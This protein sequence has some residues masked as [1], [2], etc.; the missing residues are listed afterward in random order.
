MDVFFAAIESTALSVWLRD[1]PSLLAFPFVLILH[2]VGLAFL[3]GVNVAVCARLLGL[4]AAV[5]LPSLTRYFAVM[6][7]G[8]WVN[9]ASGVALLVAYPTKSLTNPLFFVKLLFIACG[10]WAATP[11]R[12]FLS[13]PAD[14]EVPGRVKIIAVAALV[15]WAA[16]ITA[17]R[18]LAYTYSRLT[19]EF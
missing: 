19:V 18:L 9:A 1:S 3:V 2:T 10:L 11:M 5:P 7:A 4:A 13:Q 8:F 16:S 6:W 12:R 14:G 15:C 17:G